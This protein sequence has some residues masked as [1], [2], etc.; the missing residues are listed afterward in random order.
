[1]LRFSL[2]FVI[3]AVLIYFVMAGNRTPLP[4]NHHPIE[5]GMSDAQVKAF[6]EKLEQ[7][8]EQLADDKNNRETITQI[9]NIY[10]DL[11][12]YAE[13]ISYYEQALTIEPDDPTVLADCGVMYFKAGDSDKA[14]TYIDRAIILQ[15]DLAQPWFNKGLILMA[16]KNEPMQAVETWR[17]YIEL[18]PESEQ[19][20]FI[21]QQIDIVES[22]FRQDN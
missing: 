21:Q 5:M 14:L 12:Q 16:G 15:P 1:M 13:A 7:L 10:Y 19:A 18:A 3:G 6:T 11:D 8:K 22:S 4:G 20:K 2:I 9:A 17:H